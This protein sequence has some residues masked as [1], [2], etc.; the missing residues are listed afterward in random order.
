MRIEPHFD[1]GLDFAEVSEET[2]YGKV[3]VSWHMCNGQTA[4]HIVVP[5][6]TTA[7]I[8]LKD[9]IKEVTGSGTYDYIL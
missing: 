9:Q 3:S 5:V 8:C 2:P 4:V 1:C 6:N 7:E